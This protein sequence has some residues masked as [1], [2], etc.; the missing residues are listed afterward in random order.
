M[1][2][3]APPRWCPRSGSPG[4]GVRRPHTPPSSPTRD[5]RRS[6]AAQVSAF[7]HSHSFDR[8][9][10]RPSS[11]VAVELM[12]TPDQSGDVLA[13]IRCQRRGTRR[14]LVQQ[15]RRVSTNEV[16]GE[17]LTPAEVSALVHE[18][19]R[20][21]D[22]DLMVV[23]YQPRVQVVGDV[24]DLTRPTAPTTINGPPGLDHI[25]P[26]VKLFEPPLLT[27][28]VEADPAKLDLDRPHPERPNEDV[29]RFA[30]PVPVTSQ[31]Q[32]FVRQSGKPPRE[33]ILAP[34]ARRALLNTMLHLL[35]AVPGANDLLP[36]PL[37]SRHRLLFL[38][39]AHREHALEEAL[40]P[41]R[42]LQ[43]VRRLP[44]P[45]LPSRQVSLGSLQLL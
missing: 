40:R 42:L 41:A 23:T 31:H 10:S 45:A 17:V 39:R 19:H 18:H 35:P 29:I 27:D 32:P 5:H 3:A 11:S 4:A 12:I 13:G 21:A 43:L 30:P 15:V 20:G 34:D 6:G 9:L 44:I 28:R 38:G 37:G 22:H 14:D 7:Q 26:P 25:A 8:R 33:G 24:V 36:R 1:S 16:N 2:P